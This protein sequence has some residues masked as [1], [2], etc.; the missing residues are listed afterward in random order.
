[1]GEIASSRWAQPQVETATDHTHLVLAQDAKHGE[2][3]LRLIAP[4]DRAARVEFLEHRL[5]PLLGSRPLHPAHSRSPAVLLVISLLVVLAGCGGAANERHLSRS[6][7][8]ADWP[9]TVE[10]GTL[11]CEGAGAV[12]FKA[13]GTT[14]AVNGFANGMAEQ[15]GWADV[16]DI[17]ADDASS[18]GGKKNIGRLIDDGLKLCPS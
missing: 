9:L 15:H 1:M 13:G 8:G 16:A 17:W 11:R 4:A 3:Q 18:D 12:V 6:D 2:P 5:G 7:Y 14:Y 10:S